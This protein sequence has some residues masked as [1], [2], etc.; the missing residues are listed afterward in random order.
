LLAYGEERKK[1]TSLRTRTQNLKRISTR[2]RLLHMTGN[3]ESP[4]FDVPTNS[5]EHCLMSIRYLHFNNNKIIIIYS[6]RRQR[7]AV[8]SSRS[9]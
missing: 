5:D 8:H 3:Y 9:P 4:S 2:K 6:P 7:L 1:L